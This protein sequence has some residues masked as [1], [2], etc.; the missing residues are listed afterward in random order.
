A[1]ARALSRERAAGGVAAPRTRQHETAPPATE[2]VQVHHLLRVGRRGALT[3]RVS[4]GLERRGAGSD[5][6]RNASGRSSTAVIPR[7]RRYG[8]FSRSPGRTDPHDPLAR[9]TVG[10]SRPVLAPATPRPAGTRARTR[11][12]RRCARPSGPPAGS[13][14]A[15]RDRARSA[16]AAGT[17]S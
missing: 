1:G 16:P 13:W 12:G 15:P 9:L 7:S 17:P 10:S 11:A 3:R 2:S 6:R 5:V 4:T 8:I 14:R